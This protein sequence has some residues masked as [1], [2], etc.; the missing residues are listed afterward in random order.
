MLK[1]LRFLSFPWN[2]LGPVNSSRDTM[3]AH[4]ENIVVIDRNHIR[5]F[6]ITDPDRR[7]AA[8]QDEIREHKC[9]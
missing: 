3:R 9:P 2:K 7:F 8:V 6:P 5:P 1:V 4:R